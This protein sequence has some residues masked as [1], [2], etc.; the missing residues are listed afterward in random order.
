[1]LNGNIVKITE[2]NKM[3]KRK[4]K[5]RQTK[6]DFITSKQLKKLLCVWE[7]K[8]SHSTGNNKDQKRMKSVYIDL[9]EIWHYKTIMKLNKLNWENYNTH[10]KIIWVK[11]KLSGVKLAFLV[12]ELSEEGHTTL[13]RWGCVL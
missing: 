12:L 3:E 6:P 5:N 1:M 13:I 7:K 8:W 10:Q 4:E 2:H 11:G 9:N